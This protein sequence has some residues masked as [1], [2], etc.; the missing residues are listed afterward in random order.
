MLYLKSWEHSEIPTIFPWCSQYWSLY[1]HFIPIRCP[2]KFPFY[3]HHLGK[4]WIIPFIYLYSHAILTILHD[5]PIVF[6]WYSHILHQI[7]ILLPFPMVIPLDLP[8]FTI[9]ILF[10]VDCP[11]YQC[12][13]HFTYYSHTIH[14]LLDRIILFP[15][16]SHTIPIL[17]PYYS[18]PIPCPFLI[19]PSQPLR[20][21]CRTSWIP[22]AAAPRRRC[23]RRRAAPR[24]AAPGRGGPRRS[25][26]PWQRKST[27][28]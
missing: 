10:P 19:I 23:R 4:I 9:P 5:I 18:Q 1:S 14:S 26:G 11:F 27:G 6:P 2:L 15:Y 12:Y 20:P 3:I 24:A 16:Y 28:F 25:R 13:F 21:T 17:F 22:P 7:P 8:I